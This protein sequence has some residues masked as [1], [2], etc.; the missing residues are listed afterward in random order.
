MMDR[1]ALVAAMQAL[2][3]RRDKTNDSDEKAKLDAQVKDLSTTITRL[4]LD[5]LDVSSQRV[6]QSADA[7]EAILRKAQL[8][9][10]DRAL[11]ASAR[12]LAEAALT[13]S[14]E[15][16]KVFAFEGPRALDTDDADAD[17]DIA[18][19]VTESPEK[20]EA[21]G[22]SA[23]ASE[24]TQEVAAAPPAS[25]SAGLPPIVT[26]RKLDQL[27]DDYQFCWNACVIRPERR[28]DVQFAAD[29]LRR[30]E[31][32]YREVSK[33]TGVPWQ[34][35]G[36]MH[37]LECGYD[38]NKHLHNGDSLGA[39]TV[40]VP[41]GRPPAWKAGSPWEDSAVDA[42]KLKKLDQ[43]KDWTLPRVLYALE[44]FNGFGYR[45]QGIRSPYLWSF[46]NLYDRGKYIADHKFDP[47]VES[48][49]VGSAVVLKLLSDRGLWP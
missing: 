2:I 40:R 28:A 27:R 21:A 18:A 23:P 32:R 11:D 19:P 48:K 3:A 15:A 37:G 41:A 30:G 26:G 1:N 17:V 20:V 6:A 47:K 35:I 31:A 12:K 29:R 16:S 5:S 14:N 10:F 24:R 46:S 25:A 39:A 42:V 7:V 9:P 44:A 38:F 43:V 36:L 22:P 4:A 34:L 8:D 49:Q 45:G 13:L 33:K